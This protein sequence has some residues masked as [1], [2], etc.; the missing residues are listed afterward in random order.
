MKNWRSK[1]GVAIEASGVGAFCQ[2]KE[3]LTAEV[4]RSIVSRVG[5]SKSR[6]KR[7]V[8]Y[9]CPFCKTWHVGTPPPK[10]VRQW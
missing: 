5:R 6:D 4:A 3:Q 9:K 10:A 2:G 8:A 1:E 7:R